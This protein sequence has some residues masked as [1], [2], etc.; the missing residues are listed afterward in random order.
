VYDALDR[1]TARTLANG[2]TQTRQY[3]TAG[4]GTVIASPVAAYT[5]TYDAV[6]NRVSLVE[7]DG[8][9]VTYGYDASYQ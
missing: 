6:G 3:D 2:L 1:E 8:T 5:A 4:R 9:R 7:L